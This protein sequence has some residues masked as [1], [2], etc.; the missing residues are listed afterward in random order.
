M[1][2]SRRSMR[3]GDLVVERPARAHVFERFGIDYCCGGSRSLGDAC[4]G[5]GVAVDMVEEALRES[6]AR[7]ASPDERDWSTESLTHLMD[8]IVEVHHTYLRTELP[9]LQETVRKVAQAHDERHPEVLQVERVFE[10][11]REELTLHMEKEERILFPAI[12]QMEEA[13]PAG[14]AG[15]DGLLPPIRMM[16]QEHDSAGNALRSLRS[17]TRGYEMPEDGCRTYMVMLD[18]LKKLE[19]DLHAHIHKEN[20]ILFPRAAGVAPAEGPGR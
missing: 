17:L 12:R 8:H 14:T 9:F 18:R 10:A 7:D 6:D 4:S 13:G 15:R 3:I 11:L 1:E 2:E 16:E 20:N 5:A 19:E